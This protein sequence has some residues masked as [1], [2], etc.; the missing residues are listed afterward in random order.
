MTAIKFFLKWA[1]GFIATISEEIDNVLM[2]PN[3]LEKEAKT[4]NQNNYPR[5]TNG[6]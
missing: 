3:F 6:K 1:I 4:T 2:V 5:L